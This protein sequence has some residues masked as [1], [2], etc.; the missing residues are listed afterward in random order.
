MSTR[1]AADALY[2]FLTA[3]PRDPDAL[4][5]DVRRSTQ[6]KARE[7]VAL[8]ERLRVELADALRS[9]AVRLA[10]AVAAGGR[11]FAFGNG[12]SATDAQAVAALFA[13]PPRGRPVPALALPADVATVTALANDVGFDVVY[14][15]QLAALAAPGDVAVAL[16]TSGSSGNVIRA[17]EEARR[18]GILTIGLAGYD[19]GRM[20]ES[21]LVDH[22]LVVP[23]TSVHRIQ[24]AQTTIYQVL[25]ELMQAA[26]AG[27]SL[28]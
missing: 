15:R 26:L 28:R 11:V 5:Q 4:L 24:E 14:A 16:S 12:G 23:S 18:R 7:I 3:T 17:L 22:L 1:P 6:A 9:A 19:G 21:G 27:R 13:C 2:P 10:E 25:W 8:R 20:A